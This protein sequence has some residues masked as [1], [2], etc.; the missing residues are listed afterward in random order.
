M[1]QRVELPPMT[2]EKVCVAVCFSDSHFWNSPPVSRQCEDWFEVQDRVISQLKS[3][4]SATM[5]TPYE[6]P[7]AFIFAGDLFDRWNAPAEIVNFLLKTLPDGV[8]AV[9]GNHDLCHESWGD[10]KK[11]AFYTL[12]AAGKINLIMPQQ[13]HEV[14]GA[15]AMRLRGFPCGFDPKPHEKTHEDALCLNVAVVH[16]YLWTKECSHLGARKEDRLKNT[17]SCLRGHDVAIFGDNHST[18]QVQPKDANYPTVLNVGTLIPRKIDE[19]CKTPQ[20]GLIWSDGSVTRKSLDTSLDK[21]SD[22]EQVAKKLI[23][24]EGALR[25]FVTELEGLEGAAID[26]ID[27]LRREASKKNA[28]EWVKQILFSATEERR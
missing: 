9:P 13:A 27:A 14:S 25:E 19:K 22:P 4:A 20:V 17:W 10:L 1:R 15:I 28:E 11:T 7:P 3:I 8:W 2:K 24:D 6:P 23:K 12:V 16:H 5:A 18:F 21:W 26:Y